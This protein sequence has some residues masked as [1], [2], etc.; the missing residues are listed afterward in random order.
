MAHVS[1]LRSTEHTAS[2]GLGRVRVRPGKK[3]GYPQGRLRASSQS[4]Q[5]PLEAGNAGTALI[6]V[7]LGTPHINPC[8]V[9][10]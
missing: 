6:R 8:F 3:I 10:L 1:R 5:R 2:V 7:H 4:S 9:E